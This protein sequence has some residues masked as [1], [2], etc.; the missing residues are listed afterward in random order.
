MRLFPVWFDSA[1]ADFC[2][3]GVLKK[4]ITSAMRRVKQIA[5]SANSASPIAYFLIQSHAE[6]Q[7]TQRFLEQISVSFAG[8]KNNAHAEAQRRKGFQIRFPCAL[9]IIRTIE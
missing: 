7:R 1:S 5:N 8:E 9:A 2:H 6:A 4:I 3:T